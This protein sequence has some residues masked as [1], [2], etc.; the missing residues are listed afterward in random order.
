MSPERTISPINNNIQP[1]SFNTS[2]PNEDNMEQ[3]HKKV[4]SMSPKAKSPLTNLLD[5]ISPRTETKLEKT[6]YIQSELDALGEF[7]VL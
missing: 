2:M 1:F 7:C 5:K 6:K 4:L 3:L